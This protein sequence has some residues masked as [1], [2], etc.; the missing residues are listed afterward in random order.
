LLPQNK[1]E[2]FDWPTNQERPFKSGNIFTSK[3][4]SSL[5]FEDREYFYGFYWPQ[6]TWAEPQGPICSL[7]L[8]PER[9]WP[10]NCFWPYFECLGENTTFDGRKLKLVWIRS[11]RIRAESQG[12]Q[13]A[14][15]YLVFSETAIQIIRNSQ[16]S[17]KSWLKNF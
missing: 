5:S 4:Y 15:L 1:S 10:K 8:H 12:P 2:A 13:F 14:F 7:K 9:K 16:I 6:R 17:T 3:D 11:L